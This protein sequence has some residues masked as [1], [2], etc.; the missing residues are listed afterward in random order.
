MIFKQLVRAQLKG[1]EINYANTEAIYLS[2][3]F[4]ADSDVRFGQPRF[5]NGGLL[6]EKELFC[7]N[8]ALTDEIEKYLDG[9]DPDPGMESEMVNHLLEVFGMSMEVE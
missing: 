5:E 8:A 7:T 6:D 2:T 9:E 4:A 1:D 3:P